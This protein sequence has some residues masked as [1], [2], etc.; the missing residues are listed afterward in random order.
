MTNLASQIKAA[1]AK[2]DRYS[3][4]HNECGHG[5]NPHMAEHDRLVAEATEAHIQEIIANVEIY[6]ARWNAAVKKY[7]TKKG[8]PASAIRKVEEEAGITMNT[9]M[10]VKSR[11]S[12]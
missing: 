11:M 12:A 4:T 6:K 1:A 8:L 10:L 5:F 9:M 3:R 7:S 2:A